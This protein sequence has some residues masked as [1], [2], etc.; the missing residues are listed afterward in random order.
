MS[1][2]VGFVEGE[3]RPA[4]IE[5]PLTA[6]SWLTILPVQGA[7]AFDRITGGRVLASVPL[8]GILLGVLG[9]GLAGLG[10]LFQIT[11]L[12]T[13]VVIVC[14][15]ELFTRFMHLDGL[16]DVADALGSYAPPERA[17]EIIA[18]PTTGLIGMG[19]VFISLTLQIASFDALISRGYWWM[20]FFAPVIGRL[21]SIFSAH[22][23]LK[24]MRPTGFGAMMIGTVPTT[25]IAIWLSIVSTA[26]V[27]IPLIIEAPTVAIIVI[28]SLL[29]SIGIA[30]LGIRHCNRRF[31]GMNGDTI[32]FIMHSC[33]AASAVFLA[34]GVCVL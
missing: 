33:T 16:A 11:P 29:L 31:E 5:G 4:I 15:W 22:S 23:T 24:P 9:A 18:D 14:F 8:I 27:G 7:T 26:S 32:G 28:T 2:K 19:S 6:L 21:C 17:R 20:I 34:V 10:F 3:H 1:G 25:T 13:A 30:V 12:L